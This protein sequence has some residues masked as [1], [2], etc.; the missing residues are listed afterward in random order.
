MYFSIILLSYCLI[1]STYA[2]ND[3]DPFKRAVNRTFI[4]F[5]KGMHRENSRL[6]LLHK[7]I[8]CKEKYC[9]KFFSCNLYVKQININKKFH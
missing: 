5:E 7:K 4:G 3:V 1:L 9:S 8:F 6:K 2:E